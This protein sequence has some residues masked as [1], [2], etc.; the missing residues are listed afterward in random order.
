MLYLTGMH[1]LNIVCSLNTCGV[2]NESE[3]EWKN[4]DFAESEER[5]FKEYGIES[6]VRI[7]E[8]KDKI[9][10]ANHI[11]ALLDLLE[12]EQFDTAKGMRRFIGNSQYDEEVFNRVYMM[13]SLDH[14]KDIDHFMEKEYMIHWVNF[15]EKMRLD[16]KAQWKRAHLQA[17]SNTL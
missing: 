15:K 7:P 14:W 3:L 6:D 8:H 10:V 11:R 16:K 13:K 9:C 5:F 4:V 17:L 2:S 12:L 1:A